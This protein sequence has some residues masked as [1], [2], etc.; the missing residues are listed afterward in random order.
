MVYF[1]SIASTSYLVANFRGMRPLESCT[2]TSIPGVARR[3]FTVPILLYSAAQCNA[4]FL[5]YTEYNINVTMDTGPHRNL[6]IIFMNIQHNSNIVHVHTL[7]VELLHTCKHVHVYVCSTNM[8]VT[9]H[10]YILFDALMLLHVPVHVCNGY[11]II[12]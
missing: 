9:Q 6:H 2:F 12:Y 7:Q 5:S 1:R 3:A 4:V 10:K 8:F 11:I